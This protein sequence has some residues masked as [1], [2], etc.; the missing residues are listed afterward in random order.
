MQGLSVL[1]NPASNPAYPEYPVMLTHKKYQYL[2][3][4]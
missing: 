2:A 1:D 3:Q 4:R